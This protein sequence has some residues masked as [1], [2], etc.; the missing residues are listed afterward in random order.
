MRMGHSNT[1]IIRTSRKTIA[2]QIKDSGELLIR[3]PFWVS[4]DSLRSLMHKK[5]SWIDKKRQFVKQR[6]KYR[7]EKRFIDGE[8]FLYLGQAYKLRII[9]SH[10][11]GLFLDSEFLLSQPCLKFARDLFIKWYREEAKKKIKQR[12][13]L[14]SSKIGAS[15]NKINI[16][17]AR[18]RWGSCS[19]KGNLNFAWRLIM[20]PLEIIDYVVVHEL[21]HLTEKNHSRNFWEKLEGLFPNYRSCKQW[22]REKGYLLDIYLRK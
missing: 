20:A 16:T 21:I 5:Q 1:K 22:L 8:T 11:L 3:A 6:N 2:L 9:P 10:P 7:V 4:R 13:D 12:V 15:Y 19:M 18:G 17:C 14:Y